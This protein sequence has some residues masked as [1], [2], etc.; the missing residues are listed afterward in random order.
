MGGFRAGATARAPMPANC[1]NSS[2]RRPRA[3]AMRT[4]RDA[5]MA[6]PA[7]RRNAMHIDRPDPNAEFHARERLRVLF[8][9]GSL[10]LGLLAAVQV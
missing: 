9:I 6:A 5:A 10:L 4:R 8:A 1:H 3:G 7:Q 2:A